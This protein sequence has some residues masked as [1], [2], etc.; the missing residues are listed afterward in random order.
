MDLTQLIWYQKNQVVLS[1]GESWTPASGK[2]FGRPVF[3]DKKIFWPQFNFCLFSQST[4][5]WKRRFV[6]FR[7]DRDFYRW[8]FSEFEFRETLGISQFSA[9]CHE[10]E[11]KNL[12]RLFN[13][14]RLTDWLI[15]FFKIMQLG[16]VAKNDTGVFHVEVILW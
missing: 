10:F 14:N 9:D 1:S 11:K 8:E 4:F 12:G 7:F 6:S 3:L 13:L 2:S 15:D 5:L 16:F